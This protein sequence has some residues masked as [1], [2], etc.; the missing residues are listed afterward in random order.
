[1]I[2]EI[3]METGRT[4]TGEIKMENLATGETK[5]KTGKARTG[6][7]KMEKKETGRRV[8]KMVILV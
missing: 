6:M 2:G 3:R 4:M 5:T 1:M 7:T 8:I